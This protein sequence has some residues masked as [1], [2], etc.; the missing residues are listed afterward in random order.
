MWLGPIWLSFH[1]QT[2][3]MILHSISLKH[4]NM[5]YLH[6]F[7]CTDYGLYRFSDYIQGLHL[8]VLHTGKLFQLLL[9]LLGMVFL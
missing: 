9:V 2:F 6:V 1:L 7:N 3:L 4:K 5:Y 8:P